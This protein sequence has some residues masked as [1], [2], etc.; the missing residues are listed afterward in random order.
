MDFKKL[1]TS[2]FLAFPM[3]NSPIS[4][5]YPWPPS[6]KLGLLPKQRR[7][8]SRRQVGNTRLQG[9]QTNALP[10]FSALFAILTQIIS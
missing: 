5:G 1:Q 8:V 4:L 9:R 10:I 6:A 7:T 2:F 3:K